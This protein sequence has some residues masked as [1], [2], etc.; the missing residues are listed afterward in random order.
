MVPDGHH[1]R[2]KCG[3]RLYGIC[4]E[5]GPDCDNAMQ[6]LFHHCLATMIVKEVSVDEKED[7]GDDITAGPV[8]PPPYVELLSEFVSLKRGGGG[9]RQW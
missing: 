1:C 4:G 2:R 3:G 5:A 8:P 7:T 6:R 9:V